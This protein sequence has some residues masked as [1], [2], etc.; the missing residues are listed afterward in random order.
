MNL[1]RGSYHCM[2]KTPLDVDPHRYL[3]PLY[4]FLPTQ[5]LEQPLVL[6]TFDVMVNFLGTNLE[7]ILALIEFIEMVS[8]S[9]CLLQRVPQVWS[10]TQFNS[11][12]LSQSWMVVK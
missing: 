3:Y 9:V 4:G 6:V 7:G 8:R 2:R 10:L 1:L 12:S 11:A 5:H